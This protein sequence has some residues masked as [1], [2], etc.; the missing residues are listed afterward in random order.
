MKQR[1]R[2]IE[3][4]SMSA[5]DLFAAAMGA[6]A[7]LAII[8]LPYYQNEVIERTP[9]NGIAD[10]LRAAED[11]AVETKIK[12]KALEKKRSASAANVSD[13]ESQAQKLLAELRAAEAALK[14]KKA[15]AQRAVV[16]PEPIAEEP[17]PCLLYTSPSPR[18][19][20][21]SRMPSS[22]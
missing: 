4:F 20:S 11:S 2:E 18:D 10:L 21:T 7:L 22:A 15:Q 13:I 6:F 5:I 16:V 3:V 1:A 8:L 14:E 12:K 17:A 19:L 9:E